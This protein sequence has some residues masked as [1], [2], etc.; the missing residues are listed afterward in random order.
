MTIAETSQNDLSKHYIDPYAYACVRT[1]MIVYF[2][3]NDFFLR[4]L[5]SII[6]T[7]LICFFFC[8]LG[9]SRNTL[10]SDDKLIP[11]S[12]YNRLEELERKGRCEI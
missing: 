2:D 5:L 9:R 6:K 11:L 12:Q 4:N 10:N 7:L 8:L 1:G 3:G